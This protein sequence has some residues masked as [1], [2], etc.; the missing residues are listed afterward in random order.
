MRGFLT[1]LRL[2]RLRLNRLRVRG[3]RL[4]RLHLTRRRAVALG[5]PTA[6]V[7]VGALGFAPLV[8]SEVVAEAARR[9]MDVTV[10]AVRPAWF[11]ARLVG[12]TAR[13]QGV[14]AAQARLDEVVVRL[15]A[16]L[17]VRRL[18]VHGGDVRLTGTEET[19]RD[20]LRTWRDGRATASPR[21]HG[22]MSVAVDGIS[23]RWDEGV[24]NEPRVEA[25]GIG[26]T[27]DDRGLR[28]TLSDARARLGNGVV[29]LSNGAGDLDPAGALVRA[30]AASLVVQ[31]SSRADTGPATPPESEAPPAAPPLSPAV[32]RLAHHRP[33]APGAMPAA[34]APATPLVPLP[35]L[36]GA[37]A[38]AVA[39]ALLLREHISERTLD[40]AQVTVDALTW[41]ITP[42]GE[43]VPFT[44]GPGPLSVA[45]SKSGLGVRFSSDP[46]T[47]TTPLAVEAKVPTD[48]EDIE[49]TLEGGPVSLSLLGIQDGAA[50]L[51]DVSRATVTGRARVV[52]AGDGSALTFDAE[53]GTRGLSISSKTLAPEVVRGI[54]LQ[55]RARGALTSGGELRVDDVAA[56]LG[57]IQVAAGGTLDQQPDH[58]AGAF[59]FEVPAT[60]CQSLLDSIPT[61][62]LPTLRGT[63][64]AGQFRASGRFAFDTR[65]LDDLVFDYDLRDGCR[66]VRVPPTLARERFVQPFSHEIY[67][68]DGTTGERTTGPGAPD[69]TP[70]DQ[71]SPYM[72][73]AVL[74]TEDGAFPRHHGFNRSSIRS[75]IIANLKARRFVRGASTITMQ[76]AKNLFL[77]RDKTLSRKL[78]EVVLTDY[79]EQTFSKDE[80][81]E[82]YL[83]VIE[84]GPDVY[85]VT[86]AAEYYFGRSPAELN[87]AECLFLSSLLP[88]PLRYGAMR[89]KGEVSESR[90]KTL[91]TLMQIAHDTGRIADAELA[92]GQSESIVFWR[93]GDRPPPRPPVRARPRIGGETEDAASVPDPFDDL[94]R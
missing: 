21:R 58:V 54:D 22:S 52:L 38:H 48:G 8:R 25:R 73:V 53:A 34:A 41:K 55:L 44:L 94:P 9:R 11:G 47:A 65:S 68:P 18:E 66:V 80:L 26:V 81:M 71:I 70:L 69:W 28:L 31:W 63:A 15:S 33:R 6:V 40:G 85:G 19:L 86:D 83:N 87:L 32:A 91:H 67:L 13:L 16:G 74:T 3:L 92:E 89:D 12:V 4:T 46:A 37:R 57:S 1:R 49:L 36:R 78:E 64:I 45:R 30:R 75:S 10:G 62:L 5:L 60:G 35:D 7:L 51:V 29:E 43:T 20:E 2:A 42:A 72:Q 27:S 24:S 23:I 82:L 88:A 76:L 14:D 59:R 79:L 84:F 93:G 56:T 17:R 39:I 61:A 77:S 50:G 90:M